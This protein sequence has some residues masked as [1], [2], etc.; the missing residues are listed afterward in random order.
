VSQ[1]WFGASHQGGRRTPPLGIELGPYLL[2]ELD[3]GTVIPAQGACGVAINDSRIY[4]TSATSNSIGS[5]KLDGTGV[6]SSL[7]EGRD[8]V[9]WPIAQWPATLHPLPSEEPLPADAPSRRS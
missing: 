6:N 3:P 2:D 5:A 4:W 8:A 1:T 7:I 9:C